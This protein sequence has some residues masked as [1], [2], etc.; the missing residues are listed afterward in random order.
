MFRSPVSSLHSQKRCF[1][2]THHGAAHDDCPLFML[3]LAIPMYFVYCRIYGVP[4]RCT[5]WGGSVISSESQP[6]SMPCQPSKSSERRK[7]YKVGIELQI[8]LSC[9][10]LTS[11]VAQHHTS[12]TT[13]LTGNYQYQLETVG[14]LRNTPFIP[15]GWASFGGLLGPGH[16]TLLLGPSGCQCLWVL[17]PP[18]SVCPH[19]HHIHRGSWSCFSPVRT[20]SGTELEERC[21]QVIDQSPGT[22]ST[23][24]KQPCS[25]FPQMFPGSFLSESFM[26]LRAKSLALSSSPV[27]G[28][29]VQM[30]DFPT[31]FIQGPA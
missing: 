8:N 11:H 2:S 13:D 21:S 18:F 23:G 15:K 12:L 27:L 7:S 29:Q 17:P 10:F 31:C 20:A 9:D 16:A 1:D 26:L 6:L 24:C 25:I 28:W 22:A 19:A 4:F 14:V 5:H 30:L 3:I